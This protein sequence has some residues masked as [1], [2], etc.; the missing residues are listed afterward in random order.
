[1]RQWERPGPKLD[2]KVENWEKDLEKGEGPNLESIVVTQNPVTGGGPRGGTNVLVLN[3]TCCAPGGCE[4]KEELE[5]MR[6][7]DVKKPEDPKDMDGRAIV[8][9]LLAMVRN[10]QFCPKHWKEARRALEDDTTEPL[11]L[12]RICAGNGAGQR[13]R[14]SWQNKRLT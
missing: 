14:G 9:R 5:P 6:W 7:G 13:R 3:E 4:E 10:L 2:K 11:R 1:M 12:G 8:A